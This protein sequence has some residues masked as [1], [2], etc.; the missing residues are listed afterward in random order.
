VATLVGSYE[1]RHE[2]R[3]ALQGPALHAQV[4]A[5]LQFDDILAVAGAG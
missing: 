3:I 1:R 4:R 2:D 5:R